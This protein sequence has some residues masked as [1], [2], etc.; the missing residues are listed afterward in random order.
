MNVPNNSA[1][2]EVAK[3]AAP[4]I[5]TL[6]TLTG[7]LLGKPFEETGGL[8]ADKIN[9]WRVANADRINQ[10][11][12]RIQEDRGIH[13]RALP[14]SFAI[15]AI[16]EA[17]NAV[18]DELQET[19][20][21]LLASAVD[22]DANQRVAFVH[23][24]KQMSPNDAKLLRTIVEHGPEIIDNE[25]DMAD[26]TGLKVADAVAS[27]ATLRY[28]GLFSVSGARLSDF[29][30]MFCRACFANPEAVERFVQQQP[31]PE[32]IIM[33]DK[34]DATARMARDAKEAIQRMPKLKQADLGVA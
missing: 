23:A 3:A 6:S 33:Q 30:A 13:P 18:D 15:P 7:A 21:Q 8:I 2:A 22:D 12:R 28:L 26:K 11:R 34:S 27:L 9:S 17:S 16:Q 25:K 20:A 14:P 10:K 32:I 5:E 29:G 24:L 31:P 19:W 4:A 1:I